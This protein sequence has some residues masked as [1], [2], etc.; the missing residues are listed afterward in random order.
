VP[1]DF[2]AAI[3]MRLADLVAASGAPT[4]GL[5]AAL[6][7]AGQAVLAEHAGAGYRR[8]L[9]RHLAALALAR[10]DETSG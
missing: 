5:V 9:M 2:L 6:Q 8:P 3:A 4:A 1:E 10:M 7:G